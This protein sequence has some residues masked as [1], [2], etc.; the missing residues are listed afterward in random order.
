MINMEIKGKKLVITA[1]ITDKPTES[2]SGKS[3][4][5]CST[6]GNVFCPNDMGKEVKVGL[7]C[8]IPKS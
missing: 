5:L 1:D 4:K 3:L 6:G 2:K 7:N 8:Y